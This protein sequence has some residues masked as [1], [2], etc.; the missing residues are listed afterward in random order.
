MLILVLEFLALAAVIIV[1]GTLLARYADA[2]GDLSGM[3]GSLAGL[4]LLAGATSLPELAVDCSAAAIGAP[5]LAVGDLMGSSLFNLLILACI[6][7]AFRSRERM[8]SKLAAA[9]ALS[10]TM[11]MVLTGIAALGILLQPGWE[12]AGMGPIPLLILVCYLFGLRLVYFDQQYAMQEMGHASEATAA[13]PKGMSLR[14]A[15]LGYLIT[16]VVILAT[17]PFLAF[18]ADELAERTALGGTFVGTT[19]V[20]LST[21]LPEVATTIAAVR[22]GAVDLAVGNVFGSNSFNMTILFGVDL[23]YRN[24]Q[25][26]ALLSSVSTTHAITGL[27]TIIITGV[28]T[29]GLL[30]RAE[31]RFWLIEPDALLIV[32]LVLGALGLAYVYR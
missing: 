17:G 32:L 16:T 29:T 31:K 18:T 13:A 15:L 24:P 30:Y 22:M 23:V 20:A 27:C 4:V 12:L 28:A 2:L 14:R 11:S 9:H 25:G 10:A 21:S 5:D 19:L 3:G 26:S 8:L 7:L 6:D 1:S